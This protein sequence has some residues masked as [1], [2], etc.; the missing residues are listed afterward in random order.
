MAGAFGPFR[1]A[2]DLGRP[3][4]RR[5]KNRPSQLRVLVL[6]FVRDLRGS[7]AESVEHFEGEITAA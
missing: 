4:A 5:E 1:Y 7:D 3:V 6:D 2:A